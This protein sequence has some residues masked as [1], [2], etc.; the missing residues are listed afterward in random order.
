MGFGLVLAILRRFIIFLNEVYRSANVGCYA[1]ANKFISVLVQS[2]IYENLTR[3]ITSKRYRNII[4]RLHFAYSFVTLFAL[5]LPAQAA[6]EIQVDPGVDLGVGG[7]WQFTVRAVATEGETINTFSFLNLTGNVHQ[8][9]Q[10]DFGGNPFG[11]PTDNDGGGFNSEW[12]QFDSRVL[13]DLSDGDVVAV[14]PG[15]ALEETNDLATSGN[16]GLPQL[17][18][19]DAPTG[20][21]GISS[22][23]G[24][25]SFTL[26]PEFSGDNV[27]FLQVVT[28]LGTAFL[29]VRVDGSGGSRGDVQGLAIGVIP[30][31]ASVVLAGLALLGMVGL[32]RRRR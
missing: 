9:W 31:P 20:F 6:I 22:P 17:S 2:L 11:T 13:F 19:F 23:G 7:L 32:V 25:D 10:Y 12:Q 16:L 28:T 26:T 18:G 8:A 3:T 24:D 1:S 4:M 15:G 14:S 27:A 21:G 30:E 29:D 5:A